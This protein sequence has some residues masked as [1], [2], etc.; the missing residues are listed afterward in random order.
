MRWI[1]KG[2]IFNAP[3]DKPWAVT[4]AAVPCAEHVEQNVFRI[5]FNMSDKMNRGFISYI[6]VDIDNPSKILQISKKPILSPGPLGT[7]DDNGVTAP[8]IVNVDNKKYLYYIGWNK[9]GS[10]LYHTSIGLAISKDGGLTFKKYS[11]GPIMERNV[12]EPY[13]CS[14]PFVLIENNLWKMWYISFV[15]WEIVKKK[16]RP[17]YRINFTESND[18]INWNRENKVCIDFKNKNEW[19]ISRPCVINEGNSYKMWYS[20][21]G[22]N[23]YRIG[24]AESNN[25]V[26]WI[27]KDDEVGINISKSGWDSEMIEYPFVFD[28]KGK[29][30]MLYCGNERG[31]TGFEIFIICIFWFNFF[32]IIRC[33]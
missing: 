24:Y 18:G 23:T 15:K 13:F 1:K 10:V 7:F 8:C 29:R 25:G 4:H 21:A 17:Y 16:P 19:A 5:Y 30:Y 12:K 32:I 27:R 31:K 9:G 6:E 33:S 11:Q 14:N 22:K 26:N 3:G 2:L 28:Q 20:Y